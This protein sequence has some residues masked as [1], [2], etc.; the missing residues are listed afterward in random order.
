MADEIPVIPKVNVLVVRTGNIVNWNRL[1]RKPNLT[2]TAEVTE[3]VTAT[4]K[5]T[6]DAAN[7][8]ELQYVKELSCVDKEVPKPFHEYERGELKVIIKLCVCSADQPPEI[9]LEAIEKA[10]SD[11][12]V[13]LAETVLLSLSMFETEEE[14][15]VDQIKPYWL[16]LENLVAEER[17]LAIGV[18][19]LDKAKLEELYDWAK[20]K[21]CVNQVN[22]ASCCVMPKDLVEY[23]KQVGI[24]LQTH[25]D[26]PELIPSNRLQEAIRQCGT[27][28]DGYGWSALWLTRCTVL[29]KCRS[30]IKSKNYVLRAIRDPHRRM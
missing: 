26:P 27:E 3:C 20:V 30:I 2:P 8:T 6:I 5:K 9:V 4:V 29:V 16:L 11:L 13:T 18:A 12:R 10:M 25:N 1:K 15:T 22:L 14:I 21:P 28:Q 7:K 19:D 17:V 24:Q 23:A